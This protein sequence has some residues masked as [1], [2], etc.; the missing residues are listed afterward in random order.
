MVNTLKTSLWAQDVLYPQKSALLDVWVLQ[1]ILK[2]L[3]PFAL[4]FKQEPFLFLCEWSTC[5]TN[6]FLINNSGHSKKFYISGKVQKQPVS[7]CMACQ[8]NHSG[9]SLEGFA[10]Y[11]RRSHAHQF[12]YN[13]QNIYSFWRSIKERKEIPCRN[14]CFIFSGLTYA[15]WYSKLCCFVMYA[16]CT[17]HFIMNIQNSRSELLFVYMYRQVLSPNFYKLGTDPLFMKKGACPRLL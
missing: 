15:G 4:Y 14:L 16:T 13:K 8:L 12:I 6:V 10:L 17:R 2:L 3:L 11:E 5:S 9:W 1:D 7:D